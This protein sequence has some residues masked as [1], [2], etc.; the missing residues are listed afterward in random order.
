[1]GFAEKR[2]S[3]W[4]GRYKVSEGKY[5]TVV[6]P[7]GAVVKFA[8]KR[9]AKHAADEEEAKVRRGTW[10]DPAAGQE[11]FGEYASRWYDAQD[12]AAS[13]IQN[14]RRHI[15]EH[16]LPEFE[17]KALAG[18]LRTDVDVWEKREKAVYA[19][20]SVKTWRATLHLILEDAVDEGLIASNPAA[21]RRGRGKRAGRSRDRGPEKV[22]TD[23]LGLLLIAERA[24]LLSGRDDEFVAVI[25]KGYTGMRWGEVVGLETEFVRPGAVRVEHQLYE[26]DSGELT[27]C[28]PKDDSYRTLDAP[29]FLSALVADHMAR[30]KPAPCPCHGKR[31]VFRGQGTARTGGHQGAKLVD[32]ARRAGVSTGTVSNVLNHPERVGEEARVRVELAVRELNFVRGGTPTVTAAH[33]RRNGFATWLFTPATSGWY[34]KKAPQ[35]ARPVPLLGD[36]RPGI[37]VRGRGAHDRADACWLPIAAG[38]TPHGLRHSHRTHME[39]LGTE[40]VLMDDRMGHIDGSV[41]ARYAHVTPGMRER[42]MLGL[43]KQWEAAL[44][45]RRGMHPRSPVAALDRLLRSAF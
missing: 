17:D 29:A 35:E 30:V 4:R 18:I 37:P 19:A 12:L 10:R 32:V 16:L 39:D 34:P 6:D 5:G 22:I 14:Y 21:K 45:V 25:L 8:T 42:L 33:W 7:T 26:L 38:L 36:P 41:S 9:E 24:A 44:D 27:R 15:E 31:Y 40:K 23:P 11:T 13:T 1:M 20:S 28:P 3:Y 2:G 43:T